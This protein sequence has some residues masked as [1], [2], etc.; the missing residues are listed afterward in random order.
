MTENLK[1]WQNFTESNEDYILMRKRFKP[2]FY[3]QYYKGLQEFLYGDWEISKEY[4]E[5][6]E[7]IFIRKIFIFS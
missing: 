6:A 7:V 2:Q 3:E 4:F 5:N 1:L